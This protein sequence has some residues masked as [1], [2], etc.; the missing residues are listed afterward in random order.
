[1][2]NIVAL[3]NA[4]LLL[5]L[6]SMCV[7]QLS[8]HIMRYRFAGLQKKGETGEPNHLSGQFGAEM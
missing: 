6:F 4:S 1:M 7:A 8:H 3:M 5:Y 2:K